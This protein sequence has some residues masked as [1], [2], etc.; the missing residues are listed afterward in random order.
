M[1]LANAVKPVF[2]VIERQLSIC[3]IKVNGIKLERRFKQ[4]RASDFLFGSNRQIKKED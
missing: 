1:S 2:N 3:E 4:G